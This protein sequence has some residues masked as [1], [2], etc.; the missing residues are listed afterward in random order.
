[1]FAG[2]AIRWT[3]EHVEWLCRVGGAPGVE[4]KVCGGSISRL[5]FDKLCSNTRLTQLRIGNSILHPLPVSLARQRGLEDLRLINSHVRPAEIEALKS[6]KL[7]LMESLSGATLRADA[8]KLVLRV[9]GS[10]S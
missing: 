2:Y 4:L 8:L 3:S 5:D 7:A 1:M 6:L 10:P 9:S